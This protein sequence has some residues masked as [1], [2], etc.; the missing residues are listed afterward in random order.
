M[1]QEDQILNLLKINL[2]KLKTFM[3]FKLVN[4]LKAF[5]KVYSQYLNNIYSLD[6]IFE[7]Y[8]VNKY[9]LIWT[10]EKISI[11]IR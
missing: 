5:S 1:A 10:L 8:F 6:K 3:E 9:F 2:K 4:F 11:L 7:K